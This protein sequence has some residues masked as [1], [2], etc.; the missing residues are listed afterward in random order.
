MDVQSKSILLTHMVK[1]VNNIL[2]IIEKICARE[3]EE[4]IVVTVTD[5]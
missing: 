4:A 5:I 1:V 2:G 3:A